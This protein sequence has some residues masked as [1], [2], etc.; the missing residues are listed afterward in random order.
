MLKISR[1]HFIRNGVIMLTITALIC[2]AL[3]L[4]LM[5]ESIKVVN[6]DPDVIEPDGTSALHALVIH[7]IMSSNKGAV[8][9]P[10]GNTYDWIE[11]YNGTSRDIDLSNY[12]LSDTKNETKWIFPKTIIKAKTF[13]VIY[14]TNKTMPGLYAN[15]GLKSE[16]GETVVLRDS[17][18][19]IVDQVDVPAL[20]ANWVLARNNSGSW[21]I[22]DQ[23]TPG[24]SNTALGF[25]AYIA[26]ITKE[27][28]A[29]LISEVF[30]R[31]A[32]NFK[33]D[34][35]GLPGYIEITN[36]GT[37][38]VNLENYSI[39]DEFTSPF[40]WGFPSISL[41][42]GQSIV[43][44]TSNLNRK[45]GELHAD[46]SLNA[47]NGSV[48]LSDGT[49][50]IIDRV[51]YKMLPNGYALQRNNGV[52]EVSA[53][54]SPGYPNT[55]S[56][57]TA[58]Q[59]T[60]KTPSG[61]I[62]NE[63]MTNNNTL[64]KH[65][66]ANAYNWVELKNN[67]NTTI[68]LSEYTISESFNVLN[69]VSLPK[70]LLE[71]GAY[72]ILMGS[73]DASLSTSIYHHI[74]LK[75]NNDESL[76][77]FKGQQLQ[78]CLF[79][80]GLKAETSYGRADDHGFIYMND[81]SP[82]AANNSGVRAISIAAVS[83]IESGVYDRS[84]ITFNLLSGGN[85]YYTTNGSTPNSSSPKATQPITLSKSAVVKAIT[86]EDGKWPSEV[87]SYTYIINE[88]FTLPVVSLSMNE[89]H[90]SDLQAN[91]WNST[92]E[93]PG[94]IEYYAN[95]GGFSSPCG[96]QLFGG[97]V[98]GL[99][100][101]SFAITF[102]AQYGAS[103]LNYKVFEKRDFSVFDTL[104]LRSGSQDYETTF[105]RDILA[106]SVMEDSDT[107]EVQAFTSVI[108]F[109]NGKY[110]GLYDFREK[111]DDDFIA[112]HL[113]V[114][115]STVSVVRTGGSI[116][117]GNKIAY[118]ALMTYVDTHDLSIQSN[119]EHV[120]TLLNI[121]SYIDFWIAELFT[122]NNDVINTRYFSSTEYDDGRIS[123]IAYDFDFAWYF[124]DREYYKFMTDP[125]GMSRL[126]V[127]TLLNRRLFESEAYRT[128]FLERLSL[129]LKTIWKEEN[130]LAKLEMLYTTLKPEIRRDFQRWNLD[131]NS[132]EGNVDFLRNFI[133]SRTKSL[134]KQTK[135][136]FN[137]TQAEFDAYFGD[138]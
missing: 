53:A 112:T 52:Y 31:N 69:A 22:Y 91:P 44:Y 74:D 57:I 93:Y 2:G 126:L 18:G 125:A 4:S 134:L 78:D 15:F 65:N 137:L 1:Q 37:L 121:D 34:L 73:G 136:F 80:S 30:P 60:L 85:V 135:A 35:A 11:L 116:S 29:V 12:G 77:L 138:L 36:T 26:S 119:Y 127:S 49:G 72:I 96:V 33:S 8:A 21:V 79:A 132:W 115:E 54:L 123:M 17:G 88:K 56:G 94:Y 114:D 46:F 118:N 47:Q 50:H 62:L 124:P 48:F 104:V 6:Q 95:D 92:L 83:T 40:Q 133:K 28:G 100:K 32:G 89:A 99:P 10:Q 38:S 23:A 122:T 20:G 111:I 25:D 97:S 27:K 117:A 84:S 107:V 14:L 9:D 58:Y 128:R 41:E 81:P 130:V 13:L 43:V 63:I 64:L 82:N 120:K 101:K 98:R 42:A 61:L 59:K 110:W 76:Y 45:E 86:L 106:S 19:M 39:G 75:I 71:P 68:D 113:N 103:K 109:I 7:E 90:F 105:F 87:I 102:E 67:T 55:I 16:G 70:V 5:S 66:G 24:F 129:N 108:L 51:D 131:P 3:L